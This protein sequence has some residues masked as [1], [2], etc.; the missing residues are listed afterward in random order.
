MNI[1]WVKTSKV[2]LPILVF[3]SAC[4]VTFTMLTREHGSSGRAQQV[5]S[6]SAV[7]SVK[8]AT[9]SEI[10][11]LAKGDEVRPFPLLKSLDG[12]VVNLAESEK[13]YVLLGFTSTLCPGCSEDVDT[14]K[15]MRR[16]A[17]QENAEFY[18]VNIQN[19]RERVDR[20]AKAYGFEELPVLYDPDGQVSKRFKISFVPQYIV[21]SREG[22]VLRRWNGIMNIHPG[23]GGS[24]K[25]I[26]KQVAE[27]LSVSRRK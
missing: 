25:E 1:S 11:G 15:E 14:W 13:P 27:L 16:R 23:A 17:S 10:P 9:R 19:D 22:K 18:L 26:A 7:S 24:E 2:T 20:F 3:A 5:E 6:A 21:L 4:G 8:Y 12:K